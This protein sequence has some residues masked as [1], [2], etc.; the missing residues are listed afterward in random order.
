MMNMKNTINNNKTS[1]KQATPNILMFIPHDIGDHLHCYGHDSVRSPNLDN[2]AASGVRF[3]N[4]FTTAPEC[5]PSRAGLFTGQYTHQNGLVG[6]CHRGWEFTPATRHL[7]QRLWDNGYQTCLCG[8][9]HETGMSPAQLGYDQLIA[10]K[11]FDS[12]SICDDAVQWLQNEAPHL[13]KPWFTCVGLSDTHRPWRP[14]KDFS[15]DDVEVPAYLPD[16]PEVRADLA[17]L[18]QAV[19]D[20]DYS[21]GKVI[22][23]L[24]TSSMA[25][26]TIVIFTVD[27]GIPFPRAKSTYYDPGI[28][29]PMIM[30]GGKHFQGGKIFDQLISN[31]DYTPTILDICDL[32]I[33]EGLE[34]RSFKNLLQ[35]ETYQERDAV[36]GALYYDAFYDPIHCVRTKDFKYIRS[37]AVTSEDAAGADPE[38]LAKHETGS[39]IR[40]DDSDVQNSPSWQYIKKS[41]PFQI[42]P[43]EELYDLSKDPS[44][45]C[46]IIDDNAYADILTDMRNKLKDMMERTNSPLL[47]GHISPDLSKTRNKNINQ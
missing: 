6:L 23:T 8:V 43:P 18:H 9:N 20:M 11:E 37:F 28:R 36:F 41:G 16:V 2:L 22:D 40:A 10:Q 31:L 24:N 33:P 47:S 44:E 13:E 25:D 14:A 7:A 30:K 38:V 4:C 19:Y 39:W 32:E 35:G 46:N 27:H 26:N 34:G 3:S 42:P 12:S 45:K 15:P 1:I 21:I 5:T 29:V 17:E